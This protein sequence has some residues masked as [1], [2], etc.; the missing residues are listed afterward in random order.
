LFNVDEIETYALHCAPKSCGNSLVQNY[1]A[2]ND[3]MDPS[4]GVN[5][6]NVLRA[7]FSLVGPKSAK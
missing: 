4:S 1:G 7:A 6:T 3:E 5:F 2:N